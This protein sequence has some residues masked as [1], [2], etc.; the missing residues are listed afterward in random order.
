MPGAAR[1]AILSWRPVHARAPS[2]VRERQREPLRGS[3]WAAVPEER[4]FTIV[5]QD[6]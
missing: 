1:H 5:E 4:F 3:R 6:I 2:G